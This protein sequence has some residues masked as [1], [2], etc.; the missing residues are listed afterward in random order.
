MTDQKVKICGIDFPNPI[1]TAAGP[2]GANARMMLLAAKGGA[3]GLVTKTISITPARVPIPNIASPFPGS[4]L[5]AEKW[6]EID[7]RIM[8]NKE[9]PEAE[10]SGIPIIASVGYTPEELIV[11]TK[12]L[13]RSSAVR[14]IEFS[15]HYIEKDP[16]NLGKT[17][18]S[19]KRHTS[20]PVLAKLS[21]AVVDLEKIIK[22][23][24]PIVDGY[25]AINSLG[26]ALDFNIETL[27]PVLG[28]EDARGWL[29]GRA[30]L[31]IG[32]HFVESI[33][34]LT[35]KPVIGVGG[36]RTATDVIKYLMAGASAVQISSSAILQ[37]EQIYGRLSRNLDQWMTAHGYKHVSELTGAFRRRKQGKTYYL[38]EGPQLFPE[39]KDEFCTYCDLCANVCMYN[40]IR[41]EDKKFIFNRENCVSCGVCC[42]VCK[43]NALQMVEG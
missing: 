15:I 5:N 30:I 21:P 39:M 29:S 26:P 16:Y 12:D 18:R 28:S 32:L 22:V 41:F 38:G 8:I 23:L 42:T 9:F 31:P 36:I 40:A 3:G 43:Q 2:T 35:N 27:E 11:L 6:S 20:K 34:T 19:V 7:Y 37:G 13:E 1:W 33:S 10:K 4:L 17:A 25:V 24:D 14:A